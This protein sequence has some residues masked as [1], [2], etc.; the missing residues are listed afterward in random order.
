MVIL[1]VSMVSKRERKE[2]LRRGSDWQVDLLRSFTENSFSVRLS[3]WSRLMSVIISL[4]RINEYVGRRRR[5][6]K[7]EGLQDWQDWQRVESKGKKVQDDSQ[8][9]KWQAGTDEL[10]LSHASTSSGLT[11]EAAETERKEPI[12]KREGATGQKDGKS[13]LSF[14]VCLFCLSVL[15]VLL[16]P[17]D[18]VAPATPE[19]FSLWLRKK[20]GA[21]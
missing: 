6:G 17:F 21:G 7:K 4:L 12:A 16:L 15:S 10:T 19:I 18:Q 11:M 9:G 3:C 14:V 1:K 13:A 2:A 8:K 5:C 20:F